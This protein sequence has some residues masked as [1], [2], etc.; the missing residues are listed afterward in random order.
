VE[1][2]IAC[3]GCGVPAEIAQRFVLAST[4][5]AVEH[6][7][8]N[9]VAGH[10]Y[11]MATDRLPAITGAVNYSAAADRQAACSADFGAVLGR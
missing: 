11:R 3:P 8:V 4:D 9:C 5:G 1:S 10:H 6:I 2:L 7:A